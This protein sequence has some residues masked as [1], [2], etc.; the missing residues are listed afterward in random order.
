MDPSWA[1]IPSK[2]TAGCHHRDHRRSRVYVGLLHAGGFGCEYGVDPEHHHPVRCDVL[3]GQCHADFAGYRRHCPDH[4]HGGGCQRFDFERIREELAAEESM[5]GAL[6]AGYSKAFST[7]FDSNLTTL[8]ASVIL[9]FMGTGPVKGFGVT[10]TI[11]VTVSMFT[12][13]VVTRLIFDWLLAKNW[14][15]SSTCCR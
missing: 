15:K 5:R 9:I 7:I 1:R 6:A 8:I 3:G 12:A 14:L 13:L 4:W 2:R 11:G 10:L